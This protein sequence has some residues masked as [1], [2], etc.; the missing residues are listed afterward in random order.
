MQK[1]FFYF[2]VN[3]HGMSSKD[4]Y[5]QLK[6]RDTILAMEKEFV[7]L[8]H[9]LLDMKE[10]TVYMNECSVLVIK[11][12]ELVLNKKSPELKTPE[13]V[14]AHRIQ[15]KRVAKKTLSFSNQITTDIQIKKENIEKVE[16]NDIV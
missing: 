8:L 14:L 6:K 7:K 16:E 13:P 5:I 15:A 4:I 1:L 3:K 10:K 2:V 12:E 9:S 11:S